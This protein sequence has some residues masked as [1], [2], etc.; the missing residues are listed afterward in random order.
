MLRILF[1]GLKFDYGKPELGPS[2]ELHNFVGAL[3]HMDGV[4]VTFYPVDEQMRILGRD[5]M[6]D[7]LI[8]TVQ[9]STPDLL[10]CCLYTE[11]IKRDTIEYVTGR[12]ST[13]TFN[14]FCDDH[15]RF[16]TFSRHWAPLFTAVATT[17]PQSVAKYA[18]CG[19]HNVIRSQWAANHH[20]Y[21]PQQ[22][23]SGN[24]GNYT[25]SFVGQRH[26]NR[27]HYITALQRQGLPIKAFG[28]GF[29][30]GRIEFRRMLEVFSWS[31]INLNFSSTPARGAAHLWK[32]LAKLV[33][34]KELG[35]YRFN[36]HRIKDNLLSLAGAMR[37]QIK[38]RIFEIPACG[39][40]LMT[41]RDDSLKEYYVP[42]QEIVFFEDADDLVEKCRYYLKHEDERRAIAEAGYRRTL[43]EH[44]YAHRFNQ[45]FQQ[46]GLL[47]RC[48]KIYSGAPQL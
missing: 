48:G 1:A 4:E 9:R 12:T 10:F 17:D 40:F 28:T 8:R 36:A 46:M 25:I 27:G 14:W 5:G 6:N 19:I 11:E 20:I 31:R 18:H 39:G 43:V 32:Q 45:I 7:D 2:F 3:K 33:V 34:K 16:W 13:K 29:P 21:Q 15:W 26:G 42:G 41:T 30:A 35:R 24:P 37:P 23:L 22:D 44:T 38:G 47:S